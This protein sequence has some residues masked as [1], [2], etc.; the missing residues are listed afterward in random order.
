MRELQEHGRLSFNELGRRVHLSPPSVA[1]RV[2]RLEEAGVIAGYHARVD[3]TRAGY[4]LAAFIQMRCERDQCLLKTS[5]AE[6][7]PEVVEIHKLSGD[8]CSMLKVRATS[9]A[10]LEGVME[11]IGRHG[12]MRTSIVMS[13]QFEHRAVEPA[14]DD[15]HRAE[16]SEGWSTRN[17]N[18]G[19]VE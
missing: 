2:R 19:T 8:Y 11:Q 13:T 16:R 15:Y 4:P 6:D 14:P 18:P 9:M 3:A 17:D 5:R 1:E 10:H 12:Q 7:Y